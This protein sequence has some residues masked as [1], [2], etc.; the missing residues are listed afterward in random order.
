MADARPDTFT[1]SV[2]RSGGFA[3]LKREW[4][5]TTADAPATDWRSLVD[6]CPWNVVGL[7]RPSPD[8]FVWRIDVAEG[9]RGRHAT[10]PDTGL[11]GAWR[12]LVDAVQAATK[13]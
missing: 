10:L 3:G 12:V 6:A 2:V 4:R 7:A 1:I 11:V 8:R 13:A 5:V 9:K